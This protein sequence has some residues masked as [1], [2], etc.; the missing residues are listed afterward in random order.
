[1]KEFWNKNSQII[2]LILVVLVVVGIIY[3]IGKRQGKKYVPDDILIP[4]D[5]QSP[6]TPGMY[7]PGPITDGL[8][9]DLDEVF[10]VHEAEPYRAALKLSNSQLAAVYND[11]NKRYAKEFDS[12]TIIQAIQGEYTVWNYD[13][14]LIAGELVRRFKTLPGAQG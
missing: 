11:W 2:I 10:G 8:Y 12:K 6:G 4:S 1:M 3:W 7:N 13:W 14:W 9:E 5:T